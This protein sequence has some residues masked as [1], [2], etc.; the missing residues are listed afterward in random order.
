[1]KDFTIWFLTVSTIS[2]II[3]W[4]GYEIVIYFCNNYKF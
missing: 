4:V 3:F 2:G 1:M